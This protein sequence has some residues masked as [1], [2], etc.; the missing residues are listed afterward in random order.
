M[1]ENELVG[2][3]AHI[4]TAYVENNSVAV[5]DLPNLI[6]SVYSAING[7]KNG[8]AAPA[9]ETPKLTLSQIRK[10]IGVDGLVSFEDGKTYKSLKRNLA[11]KGLTPAQYRAKWGLPS[12]YPMVS[13][14]YSAARSALAKEMGLGVGGR[15]A[16]AQAAPTPAAPAQPVRAKKPKASAKG[17][18]AS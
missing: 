2:L 4:V 1:D 13:P 14:A 10:S 18:P 5:S 16:M 3:T 11:T 17:T 12:D 9:P 6:V 15:K 7:V 8:E